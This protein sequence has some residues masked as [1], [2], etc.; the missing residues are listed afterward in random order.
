MMYDPLVSPSLNHW[1]T[2]VSTLSPKEYLEMHCHPQMRR[3]IDRA[4]FGLS[5]GNPSIAYL[6]YLTGDKQSHQKQFLAAIISADVLMRN[7]F[8]MELVAATIS[9]RDSVN[10]Y[11]SDLHYNYCPGDQI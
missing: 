9:E 3:L 2:P 11:T 8:E 10:E 5:T 1:N 7:D 4:L 6:E